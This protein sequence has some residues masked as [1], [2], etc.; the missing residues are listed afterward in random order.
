MTRTSRVNSGL[1]FRP[2][3]SNSTRST[4]GC[5]WRLLSPL[6][7]LG[8]L[9]TATVGSL[10]SPTATCCRPFGAEMMLSSPGVLS[11]RTSRS[12]PSYRH[13]FGAEMMLSSPGVLSGRTS[14]SA[15]S[16]RHPFGAVMMLSPLGTLREDQPFCAVLPPLLRGRDGVG[17]KWIACRFTVEPRRVEDLPPT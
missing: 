15:P 11:G 7:G 12:A 13:P 6:R 2:T 3:R 9:R 10:R 5:E 16:Y 14:R 8:M 4:F 17:M 1:C